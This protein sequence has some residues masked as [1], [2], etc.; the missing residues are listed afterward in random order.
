MLY[1]ETPIT[2]PQIARSAFTDG[3]LSMLLKHKGILL[4]LIR[5]VC[6]I[7]LLLAVVLGCLVDC[8]SLCHMLKG[9]TALLFKFAWLL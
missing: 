1:P 9:R 4:C 7:K 8:I 2:R 3:S 5:T 6:C